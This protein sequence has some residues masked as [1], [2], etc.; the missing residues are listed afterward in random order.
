MQTLEELVI[1]ASDDPAVRLRHLRE[2]QALIAKQIEDIE[3]HGRVTTF[4]LSATAMAF[5]A[6]DVRSIS[7][8]RGSNVGQVTTTI[9]GVGFTPATV[10]SLVA[11]DGTERRAA[12]IVPQSDRSFFATFNLVGLVPGVYT[13][14]ELS[15]GAGWTTS[16][17][18]TSGSG[19]ASASDSRSISS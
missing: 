4:A 7:V 12:T 8:D 9:A 15:P 6:F 5:D 2:E 1:G 19:I 14:T 3:Q 16:Y 13:V 18:I 11:N 17:S 10:F